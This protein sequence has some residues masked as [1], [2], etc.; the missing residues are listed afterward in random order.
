M[1]TDTA[2][3]INSILTIT[4]ETL[5]PLRNSLQAQLD[6]LDRLIR[7]MQIGASAETLLTEP[8]EDIPS[9]LDASNPN[10]RISSDAV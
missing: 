2:S 3:A 7:D 9:F 1:K 8:L 10:N 5:I 6:N 4:A